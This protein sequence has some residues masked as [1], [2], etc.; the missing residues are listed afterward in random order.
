MM[1]KIVMNQ[2]IAV[3]DTYVLNPRRKEALQRAAGL[4]CRPYDAM[5]L[6][7]AFFAVS[8]IGWLWEVS[9]HF[10]RT[11]Q[12][13]NR[14]TLYGPWLPIYGTAAVMMLVL[15]KRLAQ[16]PG[17]LFGCT[18]AVCGVIEYAT[19]VVLEILFHT[20]WWDYSNMPLNIQGRI[21]VGGLM[22]FGLGGC[23]VIYLIGPAIDCRVKKLP[24]AAAAAVLIILVL[25]FICDVI[26]SFTNIRTG[27]GITAPPHLF[28]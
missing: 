6:T 9:Q 4:A 2:L 5:T 15:L 1:M 26:Y 13:V 10:V 17:I 25:I 22:L 8:L 3:N 7:V 18:V 14:G 16:R 24:K 27:A 23:A 11:G 28:S 12:L 21:C 20:R 19:S